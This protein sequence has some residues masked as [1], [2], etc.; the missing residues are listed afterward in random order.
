[1]PI[2]GTS[3]CFRLYICI[4]YIVFIVLDWL[5]TLEF[6]RRKKVVQVVQIGGGEGGGGNLDEIQKKSSIFSGER[7]LDSR[8]WKEPAVTVQTYVPESSVS[9]ELITSTPNP[10]SL[11]VIL[12]I[13]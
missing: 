11:V 3:N 2:I 6:R 5:S 13:L 12:F 10:S 4:V 8:T 7:P 9:T 1:M